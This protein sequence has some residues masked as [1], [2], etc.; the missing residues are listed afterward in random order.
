MTF[1]KRTTVQQAETQFLRGSA[2]LDAGRHRS[3]FHSFV[4]A[5]RA[6]H[7]ASALNVGYLYDTGTGVA[8]S[9]LKARAWYLRSFRRGETSAAVNLGIL[10]RETG[11]ERRAREWFRRG[12]EKGDMSA[13]IELAGILAKSTGSYRAARRLLRKAIESHELSSAEERKARKLLSDLE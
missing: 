5:A 3:A 9:T 2:A 6:G 11:D 10:Y 1:R 8:Q 12:V 4:R 7:A 13:A